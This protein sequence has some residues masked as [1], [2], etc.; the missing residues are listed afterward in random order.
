MIN[1]VQVG[2]INHVRNEPT[3]IIDSNGGISLY[4]Q[5]HRVLIVNSMKTNKKSIA[6][7]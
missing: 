7:K 2:K 4:E 5:V 3:L 6:E 1:P